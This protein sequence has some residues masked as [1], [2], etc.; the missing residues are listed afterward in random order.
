MKHFRT[1]TASTIALINVAALCN[2]KNFPLLA[3]YG[4][5]TVFFLALSAILF[6]IP[7]SLVSAELASGWPEQ[8]IYTWVKAALGHR[9]GFLAIWLQ[10][11]ES[12]IWYPTILSF[13]AST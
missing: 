2:I 8:G 9:M 6:F 1:L 13:I 7:V 11:I 5:S 3:E 12:V 4:L 10:W